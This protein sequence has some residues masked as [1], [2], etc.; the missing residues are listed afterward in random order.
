MLDNQWLAERL[1]T[2]G[3]VNQ[4]QIDAG[5]KANSEDLC[6]GLI[7]TGATTEPDLLKFLGLHFQTRFVSTEK[8]QAAKIP[9]WVLDLLSQGFCEEN[10]VLPVRCDKEKK[11]LSVV[12]PDPTDTQ[13]IE[14]IRTKAGVETVRAYVSLTHAIEAG[15]RKFYLGDLHAFSRMDQSLRQNY[16]EMMSIY[17]QRLI[18]FDDNG[19]S[20]EPPTPA[21]SEEPSAPSPPESIPLEPEEPSSPTLPPMAAP[22]AAQAA[23]L[24]AGGGLPIPPPRSGIMP[25]GPQPAAPFPQMPPQRSPTM[26]VPSLAGGFQQDAWLRLVE[27]LVTLQE[28][29]LG[30]RANHSTTVSQLAGQLA[31]QAGMQSEEAFLVR[32]A[33]M[34]HEIGKPLEMHL[35]LLSIELTEEHRAAAMGGHLD[36]SRLFSHVGLPERLVQILAALYERFDGAGSPGHLSGQ[37]IPT[38]ARLLAV[39]DAYCDLIANP[40]APGG[41][42]PNHQ[43]ALQRLRE[44]AGRGLVDPNMVSL[45]ARLPSASPSPGDSGRSLILIVDEDVRTATVL[46]GGLKNAGYDAIVVNTPGDAALS[47]LGENVSLVLSEVELRPMDGFTFLEWLRNNERT[48]HIPFMFISS[49]AGAEDVNRGF[50]LGAADYIVKPYR[51]EVVVAKIKR[52]L[53]QQ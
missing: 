34:L 2:K 49:R 30:W 10:H 3:L 31:I 23:T 20:E 16:S 14:Q 48:A 35:T 29:P 45:L 24:P 40:N 47:L 22:D 8:L 15:I 46:E 4:D 38:E 13:A 12:M 43:L 18:D 44:A 51:P 32:L 11:S 5:L 9:Q 7:S 17:E 42:C 28:Q 27:L 21:P 25:T 39:L 19:Q 50:E 6:R 36:P 26:E 53:Q 1:K 37:G 41:H 52:A 33:A